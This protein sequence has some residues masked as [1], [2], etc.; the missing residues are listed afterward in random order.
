[1]SEL[2]EIEDTDLE[3]EINVRNDLYHFK[4]AEWPTYIEDS[5]LEHV[6]GEISRDSQVSRSM[7]LTSA[8]G[9]MATACQGHIRIEQPTGNL[10]NA[11]LMLLTIAESGER[12]TTVE[13]L[14]FK[15]LRNL[16][17]ELVNEALEKE[18]NLDTQRAL[19]KAACKIVKSNLDALVKQQQKD[20]ANGFKVDSSLEREAWK[21]YENIM[22]S[23]PLS[24]IRSRFVYDDTTPQALIRTMFD[25]FKHA[26]LV[27]SESNGIFNGRAFEEL[28]LIN[29]LWDGVPVT[30]DRISKPS[31]ILSNA[32]L[33]LS[34][35]AQMQ[36]LEKFLMKRGEEA[37]G[38]GFLARFLV[39]RPEHRA[40]SR[41]LTQK[42]GEQRYVE[43]FN[44]RVEELVTLDIINQLNE[45]E[46]EKV[47]LRFSESAIRKWFACAQALEDA[48][49]EGGVYEFYKDHA[50]KLMDNISRVAGVIHFFHAKDV[51][52]QHIKLET[53]DYAYAICMRYSKHFLTYIVDEPALIKQ[54]KALVTYLFKE[55]M[56]NPP[57]E[58]DPYISDRYNPE[59]E[60]LAKP[61]KNY[62]GAY[63]REGRVIKFTAREIRQFGPPA[64]RVERNL[65]RSIELLKKM[66]FIRQQ[67]GSHTTHWELHESLVINS[68]N[69]EGNL[70]TDKSQINLTY[71]NGEEYSI[72]NLPLFEEIEFLKG[73]VVHR[74]EYEA[75]PY[76]D[77]SIY[78]KVIAFIKC[79]KITYN[80]GTSPDA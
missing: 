58:W 1:M 73:Y 60:W 51:H 50:S 65:F 76:K 47:Q 18:A 17:A 36:V 44:E 66:G 27:S 74:K 80:K 23:E 64:L 59:K 31:F 6:I 45:T 40:G 39:V 20:R 9:A 55:P 11:N 49:K 30:V 43:A 35:M 16:Q 57:K 25:H 69:Q 41:S 8:L 46:A 22:N 19:W 71:R 12:K 5:I 10:V 34:L 21:Y 72:S 67:K 54:T 15:S 63:F 79:K 61:C 70:T 48:Q 2:I 53:L 32:H 52:D 77:R 4:E 75:D 13:K 3:F 68:F 37:R 28:H 33:T 62:E 56:L 38:I 14:L 7:V 24:N 42:I 78:N 26:A 29:S